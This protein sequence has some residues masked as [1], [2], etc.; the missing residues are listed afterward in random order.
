MVTGMKYDI[1]GLIE[2]PP[3]PPAAVVLVD[4]VDQNLDPCVKHCETLLL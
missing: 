1:G 3:P 4:L 2:L